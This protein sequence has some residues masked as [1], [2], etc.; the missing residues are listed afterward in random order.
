M[1]RYHAPLFR[2][3]ARLL[4]DREEARDATQ[5]AFLKAYQALATCDRQR[6]FFS[7]IYRILVNECL[8]TLRGRRP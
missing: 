1:V 7:W 8:N 4:G 3:A 5:T 6:K 2:V